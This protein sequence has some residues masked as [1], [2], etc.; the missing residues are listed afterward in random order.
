MLSLDKVTRE[1]F[2]ACLEQD[3]EVI[4]GTG[5]ITLHLAEVVARGEGEAGRTQPFTL[6]FRGVAGLRLP[7]GTYRLQ[8]VTLGPMEL[9]LT[10]IAP[11]GEGSYFEAVFA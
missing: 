10:Q 7:Q 6:V 2:A 8:N 4:T 11:R 3:F 1:D 9:D 5:G